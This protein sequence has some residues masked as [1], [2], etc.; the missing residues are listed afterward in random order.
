MSKEYNL[1]TSR[2]SGGH[3]GGEG[4]APSQSIRRDWEQQREVLEEFYTSDCEREDI[5]LTQD[6][7]RWE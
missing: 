5:D 3:K 4:A 2:E 6:R 1:I 7:L